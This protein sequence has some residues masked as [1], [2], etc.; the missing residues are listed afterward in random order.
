[1]KTLEVF[2][3]CFSGLDVRLARRQGGSQAATDGGQIGE[4]AAAGVERKGWVLRTGC[5][6]RTRGLDSLRCQDWHSRLDC[7]PWRSAGWRLGQTKM[8]RGEA[9]RA[10]DQGVS[11]ATG[12]EPAGKTE[13]EKSPHYWSRGACSVSVLQRGG[14]GFGRPSG[15]PLGMGFSSSCPGSSCERCPVRIY[16][17]ECVLDFRWAGTF[18][19]VSEQSL[20]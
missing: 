8:P 17:N 5:S 10:R 2:H 7:E 20:I 19:T 4:D 13:K 1:M 12:R 11:P 16:G 3:D 18:L 15:W 14:P 9:D 6:K